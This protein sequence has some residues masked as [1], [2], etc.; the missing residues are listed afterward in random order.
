MGSARINV[1]AIRVPPESTI[2]PAEEVLTR[3]Q[4]AVI[5]T[6]EQERVAA[7]HAVFEAWLAESSGPGI[8]TDWVDIEGL[9]APLVGEWGRRSDFLVI[10]RPAHRGDAPERLATQAALFDTDRPVLVVPP[11]PSGAFGERVAIAWR[12]DKRTERAVLAALRLL[13]HA[14]QVHVLAGVRSGAP[15]PGLPDILVEHG[16]NA[17]SHILPIGSGTF[18]EALLD[19]AHAV[20]ADLLVMGAY[21]KSAWRELLLGG[22]T[23]YMLARADLPVLMRH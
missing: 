23:R 4:A 2:L 1:L 16:I 13:P 9:A 5:R 19:E 12:D 11:G 22:V 6:R 17:V 15:E 10:P 14:K 8:A 7:L 18:G 21:T 20:G 3:H